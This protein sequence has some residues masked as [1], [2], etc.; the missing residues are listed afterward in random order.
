VTTLR[1]GLGAPRRALRADEL[2]RLRSYLDRQGRIRLAAWAS[3]EHTGPGGVD[4][5]DHL[6]LGVPDADFEGVH[7][8]ALDRGLEHE[9]PGIHAWLDLFALSDVDAVRAFADVL[10]ERGEA[11]AGDLDPLEFRLTWEPLEAPAAAVAAFARLV[12]GLPGVERVEGCLERLWKNERLV[13]T[14]T[15]L[16]VAFSERRPDDFDLI[17]GAVVE[18]GVSASAGSSIT[19]ALP[20]D[21]R[22]RTA[23]LYAR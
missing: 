20:R 23:V 15:Q 3:H 5:D 1:E 9:L 17:R 22:V 14:E 8:Q 11:P 4:H 21:D 16:H 13:E 18:S 12:G 6:L 10:W 2:A 19:A 7:A